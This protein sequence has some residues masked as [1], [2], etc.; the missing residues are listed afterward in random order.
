MG[1]DVY[2]PQQRVFPR[3][4]TGDFFLA[5]HCQGWMRTVDPATGAV[6]P[7]LVRGL[8]QPVD[9]AVAPNGSVLILQRQLNG[10]FNGSLLRLTYDGASNASPTISSQPE[11]QTVAVGQSA[12]FEVF[13]T[14]TGQLQYQWR[15]NGTPIPGA[16]SPAYTTPI[17]SLDD[18]GDT[19]SVTVSNDF[20]SLTSDG[21]ALTVL[22]DTPPAPVITSPAAGDEFRGGQTLHLA[23]TATDAEDGVLPASA[24]SWEVALHHNTH[25]HPE[26][27][28]VT[29]TRSLDFPVPRDTETDPDIFW[30]IHHTVTDSEGISTTVSR[31]VLPI[32]STLH[33]ATVPGGRSLVL[34]G[35]PVATPLSLTAVAGVNRTL[36]APPTT[37]S[38]TAMVLDSWSTGQTASTIEFAAPRQNRTYRAFYR[39]DGGDVGNGTGLSMTYFSSPDFSDPVLTRVERVPYKNWRLGSPASGVPRDG[40][41]VRWSGMLRPQ[42]SDSYTFALPVGNGDT[43]RV[44]VDGTPVIDSNGGETASGMRSLTAGVAV[45]IVIEMSHNDGA[46]GLRLTWRSSSTPRS[47]VPGSQLMPPT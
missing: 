7:V 9:M 44:I 23:G 2:R 8:E 46:A 26:L 17:T 14:G 21:A 43:A 31:D 22:D 6:G 18:S 34:D 11:P 40:F 32:T 20:G 24:F 38:D 39:V 5:D 25:S 19:F 13:A 12:T 1:G 33:L 29:G 3:Q 37:V 10:A 41:S 30:R 28:P 4:Y 47:A 45:P 16:N 27:G 35:A 42:F 15:R 36:T